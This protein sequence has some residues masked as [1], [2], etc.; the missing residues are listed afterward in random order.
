MNRE[1]LDWVLGG[2]LVLALAVSAGAY[3]AD[4]AATDPDP[5]SFDETLSVGLTL[6]AER[7]L[8]DEVFLPNV[9]VFYSQ[10]EYVVGYYG[11]ETFVEARTA[12]AHTDQFGYP[13]SIAV[14]DYGEAD[15]AVTEDGYP[16]TDPAFQRAP[17]WTD[18]EDA[19]YLLESEARTPTG[20]TVLSFADRADA[21][22]AAETLGG[23]VQDWDGLLATE[24]ESDDAAVVR[25]SVGDR[26]DSADAL[27]ER[28]ADHDERPI[29]T[30]VGVDVETVQAGLEAAPANTTVLVPDGTYEETLEIDRP[31]TLA[32]TGDVTIRGDGNGSVVTITAAEASVR[33]LAIDGVGELATGAEAVPGEAES[34]DWDEDF[35]IFYTGADAGLSAH[36]AE[37]VSVTNVSIDTPSNGIIL[38][39]SPDAVVRNVTVDGNEVATDGF[40]GVMAFRSPGLIEASTITD[41]QDGIYL[42][43]SAGAVVRDTDVTGSVLGV[44]LMHTDDALLVGNRITEI[45][46]TGVYVMTGPEGNAIVDNHVSDT[47][48]GIYVGGTDSYTAT[49]VVTDTTVGLSM[50]ASHSIYAENVLVGNAVGAEERAMLPTNDVFGTDFV[51]NDRHAI[52]GP[53]PLRV[54]TTDGQGNY[55]QGATSVLDGTPPDRAYTATDTVDQRLHTTPGAA[56]LARAP[57]ADALAGLASSVSG[58]QRGSIVDHAPACEPTHPDRLA[59]LGVTDRKL[60]CEHP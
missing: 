48:T 5:V 20:E 54:W 39:G 35:E 17:P 29:S 55:W 49:N 15:L 12:A 21:E 57:A 37:G 31:I 10:Y 7:S 42:Y 58:M 6:E 38:R 59:A 13:L 24:F 46:N 52:A 32:G 22:A 40:A 60:T 36:V 44:H 47:Q 56:T 14:T 8:D 26:H 11:V 19:W 45:E 18:A 34:G 3:V 30:V 50:E 53:G 16:T 41:G 43:R 1:G 25:D 2:L 33:D 51:D 23:I 27:R 9:Q 4:P 28:A